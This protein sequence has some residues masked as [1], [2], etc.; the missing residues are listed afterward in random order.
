MNTKSVLYSGKVLQNS[1]TFC[2]DARPKRWMSCWLL[3]R[4]TL[5]RFTLHRVTLHGVTLQRVTCS[6]QTEVLPGQRPAQRGGG[7]GEERISR[8]PRPVRLTTDTGTASHSYRVTGFWDGKK[9]SDKKSVYL[10]YY[11]LFYNSRNFLL[12][13]VSK[14]PQINRSLWTE[15]ISIHLIV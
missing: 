10:T 6:R 1:P 5:Q 2:F 9:N 4:F 7:A 14:Y 3:Q 15:L 13:K 11:F 8:G 12:T